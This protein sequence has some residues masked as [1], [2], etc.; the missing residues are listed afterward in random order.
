[1]TLLDPR[2]YPSEE[3]A[4]LYLKRWDVELFFRDIKTTMGMDILRCQ[5]PEMIR[6]EIIMNFIAYNCVRRL[7][8]DAAKKA[9]VAVRLVSFKGSIQA[10]RN[11]EPQLNHENLSKTERR[12]I[13]NDLYGTVTGL[14][15]RQ[16]PG[17]REPRCLKRRPKN[18]Q[19]MTKPRHEMI[20]MEHRS[21]YHASV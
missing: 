16:R 5:A 17:R 10:I 13:L 18:Y 4:S 11:W 9:D 2:E 12:K 20:E 1:M 3:I 7:M 15:L 8:Y 21:R 14:P 6:K 19:L